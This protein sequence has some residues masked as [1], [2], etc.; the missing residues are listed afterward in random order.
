MSRQIIEKIRKAI[1][2]GYYDMTYHAVEEMA[3][4]GLVIYDIESA[5]LNGKI[6]KKE[7]DDPRGIK[8]I[9]KGLGTDLSTPIGV[10]GRFKETGVFLIMT[11]YKIT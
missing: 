11:V 10:V 6:T 2:S 7:K 5:I 1:K 8:Y 3:E 4:D 9:L